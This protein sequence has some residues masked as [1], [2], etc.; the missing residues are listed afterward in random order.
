[1]SI[2]TGNAGFITD[3]FPGI[4][5]AFY[6]MGVMSGLPGIS[7]ICSRDLNLLKQGYFT[8]AQLAS[9]ANKTGFSI[10]NPF[11]VKIH[12]STIIEKGVVIGN[13]VII[14]SQGCRIGAG[15]MISDSEISQTAMIGKNNIIKGLSIIAENEN[16]LSKAGRISIGDSNT[17]TDVLISDNTQE[18]I[19]IGSHNKL[20]PNL[21]IRTLFHGW[22]Y[23]GDNNDLGGDGGGVISTSYN[24][25]K[26]IGYPL[27]IGSLSTKRGAEVLGGGVY[28]I[29]HSIAEQI[30]NDVQTR[31]ISI[32]EIE[33]ELLKMFGRDY[34]E[35]ARVWMDELRDESCKGNIKFPDKPVAMFVGVVKP[36]ASVVL[37]DPEKETEIRDGSRIQHSVIVPGTNIY[38]RATVYFSIVNGKIEA[39]SKVIDQSTLDSNKLD[40]GYLDSWI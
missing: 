29:T 2:N 28:G 25:G 1:M 8:S 11:S 7:A 38:E 33:N 35:G 34:F 31:C 39:G 17:I 37:G 3:N 32:D 16:D 40:P 6:R 22:I 24:Y 36:K 23:I 9:L 12:R 19:F 13:G 14:V 18:G 27:Y 15:T 10:D 26:S 5:A 4:R 21:S 30:F 20:N